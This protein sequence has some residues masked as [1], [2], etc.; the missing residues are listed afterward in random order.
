MRAAFVSIFNTNDARAWSG[1][2]YHMHGAF[3]RAGLQVDTIDALCD[4]YSVFFRAKR[5]LKSAFG[6]ERYLRDREP[7]VLRSY[8]AQVKAAITDLRP[9]FI[10][11][12]GTLPIA[13]LQTDSPIVFWADATFAGMLNFYPEFTNLCNE[14][15]RNGNR[16]EQ[17]ALSNCE[18]AIFSSEWAAASAISNYQV[19]RER[20]KVVPYG[21]NLACGPNIKDVRQAIASRNLAAPKLIFVGVD[22]YRKGG[23]QAVSVASRLKQQGVDVEL[24][25]VGC[26]PPVRVPHF[27]K[28]HGY[29]SKRNRDQRQ[30]LSELFK[31]A[32][33]LL[34]PAGAESFGIVIAEAN[35]F[36]VPALTTNVGG[37]NS[38]V[39]RGRNGQKFDR[40]AFVEECTAY[41]VQ[42]LSSKEQYYQLCNSSFDEYDTR[43]N[44]DT[45][46]RSVLNLVGSRIAAPE[47]HQIELA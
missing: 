2:I 37:L 18:L 20:I 3:R 19:D 7:L 42:M 44:W 22:W 23:D 27:V 47:R 46:V 11:S 26:E 25:V 33:F 28:A 15:I 36:G 45:S 43:L 21:A 39:R 24:H 29:I 16:M 4:R 12:P 40:L 5:I 17:A 31:E 9:D 35:A 8:A 10:I 13:Y 34:H 30:I 41:I 38:I 1:T 32:S 14:T 6:N